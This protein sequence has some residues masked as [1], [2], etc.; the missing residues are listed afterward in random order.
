MWGGGLIHRMMFFSPSSRLLAIIIAVSSLLST[1]NSG[2]RYS[3]IR[4]S[5][6]SL[7]ISLFWSVSKLT[8]SCRLLCHPLMSH[9]HF[10][11]K[12]LKIDQTSKYTLQRQAFANS[13]I[14]LCTNSMTCKS[15]QNLADNGASISSGNYVPFQT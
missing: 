12:R 11:H 13:L 7:S 3:S 2:N 4:S 1:V 6:H 10:S 8:V 9:E 15:K 14:F 5:S